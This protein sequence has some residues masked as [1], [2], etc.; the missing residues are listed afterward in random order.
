[1]F[2][3]YNHFSLSGIGYS[4][5]SAVDLNCELS[6]RSSLSDLDLQN[7]GFFAVSDRYDFYQREIGGG[8]V[9]GGNS[10]LRRSE[11]CL[12]GICVFF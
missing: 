8:A 4:I 5:S 12:E 2:T 3:V 11:D 1:M 9:I 7:R 10:V 6:D